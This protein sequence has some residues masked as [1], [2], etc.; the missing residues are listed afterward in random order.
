[1]VGIEIEKMSAKTAMM[2]LGG[3][4][5]LAFILR[6]LCLFQISST[7]LYGLFSADSR[8]YDTFAQEA[9]KGNF[10]PKD[11]VYFNYLYPIILAIIY[12]IFGHSVMAVL[13]FQVIISCLTILMIYAITLNI[14]GNKKIAL[15]GSFI[16][17]CYDIAVFYSVLL[18]D[19]T[20]SAFLMASAV[21]ALLYADNRKQPF[22]WFSSGVIFGLLTLIRA[23]AALS[24]PFFA[25]WIYVDKRLSLRKKTLNIAFI[26]LGL[27]VS[28]AP[29][30]MRN[31]FIN[32]DFSPFPASG[33]LNFY[34]GNHSG[35]TGTY[36]SLAGILDSPGVQWR[37]SVRLASR[38]ANRSLTASEASAHW[39]SKGTEF[40]ARQP[41]QF[42]AL[43]FKKTFLF[44]NKEQLEMN[45]NFKFSKRLLPI[46]K[47]PLMPFAI[48]SPLS[49]MGIA[50][51]LKNG[52][53]DI[54]LII[55]TIISYMFSVIIIFV[56]AR[57]RF[58]LSP[59]FV[60]MAAYAIY[61]VVES[62][63]LKKTGE[64]ISFCIIFSILTLFTNANLSIVNL[65]PNFESA[66][67]NLAG[68]YHEK[69]MRDKAIEEYRRAIA[70][71]S[72]NAK[73]HQKLGEIFDSLGRRDEAS[74]EY[75]TAM[76]LD[77]DFA[78]PHINL[79]VIYY[80]EKMTDEAIAEYKKAIEI[81]PDSVEAYN[82]LGGIYYERGMKAAA[83]FSYQKALQIDPDHPQANYNIGVFYY[84]E[85][86]F[87]L[88]VYHYDKAIENGFN[89]NPQF[90][91]AI[92]PYR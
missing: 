71:N 88:A 61:S 92:E 8:Y 44:W 18:L 78:E 51:S 83:V 39:F 12:K 58:V 57:Y 73:A 47:Y 14:F 34:I 29:F 28:L 5:L 85:G 20:I 60:I 64:V 80:D 81:D 37:N 30:M 50:I 4:L 46:F 6:A 54:L 42:L 7:P 63:R 32:K 2:A 10:T 70:V 59:F 84:N 45:V 17:A 11:S 19:T 66:H 15:L 67:Y 38:Q 1:M 41:G 13:L 16:Y 33:G 25:I 23:N 9:L 27:L 40:I 43:L 77:P 87:I 3:I 48:I 69:G 56:A 52:R 49:L 55:L 74:N 62:I 24:L 75:K 86:Q 53:R 79:G 31:Y 89:G 68:V 91:K 35:A 76:A 26:A 82:N 36:V 65:K 22:P 72:M 21:M 90:S